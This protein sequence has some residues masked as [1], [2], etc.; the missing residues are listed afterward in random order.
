MFF[1]ILSI[2]AHATQRLHARADGSEGTWEWRAERGAL[3]SGYIT[4]SW[5]EAVFGFPGASQLQHL[6]NISLLLMQTE[7]DLNDMLL[8]T[9]IHVLN[10]ASCCVRAC[11]SAA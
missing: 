10:T 2:F 7:P 8:R 4:Y 1:F 6:T 9:G 11:V 5:R 3:H